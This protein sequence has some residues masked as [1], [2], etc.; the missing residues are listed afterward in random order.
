LVFEQIGSIKIAPI[1]GDELAE[2]AIVMRIRELFGC[3]TRCPTPEIIHRYMRH[4]CGIK[5][6]E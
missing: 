2:K 6:F 1:R 4:I 5:L 3:G